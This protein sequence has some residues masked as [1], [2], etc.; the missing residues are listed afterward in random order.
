M[1]GGGNDDDA[2]TLIL[3]GGIFLRAL[4]VETL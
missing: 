1:G 3:H 2:V 4:G